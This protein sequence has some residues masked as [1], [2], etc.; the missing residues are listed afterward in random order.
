[1]LLWTLAKAWRTGYFGNRWDAFLHLTV[2][3]DILLEATLIPAH[4]TVGYVWCA[5]AFAAVIGGYR[6]FIFR[7]RGWP[8]APRG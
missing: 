6:A 5:L 4:Q 2:I 8:T 3:L 1:L 7:R